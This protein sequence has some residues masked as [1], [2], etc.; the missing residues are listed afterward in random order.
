MWNFRVGFGPTQP[1]WYNR[2][3]G[4]QRD[5]DS[6]VLKGPKVY[7]PTPQHP[8]LL[9]VPDIRITNDSLFPANVR[10]GSALKHLHPYS[11]YPKP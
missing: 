1:M 9:L 3:I 6:C 11:L 5:P 2:N 10:L 8:S 4:M 7:E